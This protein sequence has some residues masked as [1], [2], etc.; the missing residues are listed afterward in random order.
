[1]FV[2]AS[3]SDPAFFPKPD[4]DKDLGSLG[5]FAFAGIGAFREGPAAEPE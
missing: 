4:A 1:V 2:E 5:P 3:D